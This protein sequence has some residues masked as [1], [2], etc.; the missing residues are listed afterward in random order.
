LFLSTITRNQFVAAQ[1]ALTAA[2]LPATML[3]G[4]VFEIASMPR[5]I[6]VVSTL[7]PARY[8]VSALQTLFQAGDVWPVL[9][10]NILYLF[11]S[12]VFWLGLTAIKTS[13]RLD[14]S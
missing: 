14:G 4:F 8:F 6:Q 11:L 13:R 1:L 2:F 9:L 5:V 12:A 10:Q 7:V 3:S